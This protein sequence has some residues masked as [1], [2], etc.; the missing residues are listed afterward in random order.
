MTQLIKKA[1]PKAL[2]FS[3]SA[4]L[5]N[6]QGGLPE[7]ILL[8]EEIRETPDKRELCFPEFRQQVAE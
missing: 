6:I 3:F 4:G 7:N 8:L 2:P 1:G 5:L